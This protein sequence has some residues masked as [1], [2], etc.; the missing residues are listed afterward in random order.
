MVDLPTLG[1]PT[2]P[3]FN[4]KRLFPFVTEAESA[5][6]D[7]H[8]QDSSSL[9]LEADMGD[10]AIEVIFGPAHRHDRKEQGKDSHRTPL[11]QTAA[12]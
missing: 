5:R 3:Q 2:I 7:A 11:Q 9:H 8:L 4:G 12:L 10:A 1:K 6:K